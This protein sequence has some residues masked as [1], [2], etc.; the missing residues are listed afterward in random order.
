MAMRINKKGQAYVPV[1][2]GACSNSV[3]ASRQVD[4]LKKIK[5]RK[6]KI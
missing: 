5:K 3:Y 2:T 1:L 6:K 4:R